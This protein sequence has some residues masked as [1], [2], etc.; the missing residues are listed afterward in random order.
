MIGIKYKD[1][2]SGIGEVTSIHYV[3]EDLTTEQRNLFT[4]VV[5]VPKPVRQAGKRAVLKVNITDLS[6]FYEYYDIDIPD[7]ND[8]LKMIEELKQRLN[9]AELALDELIL[10]GG[11]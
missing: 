4:E 8:K 3:L 9:L 10:G 2:G 5:E 1:L 11:V 6:F 7:E